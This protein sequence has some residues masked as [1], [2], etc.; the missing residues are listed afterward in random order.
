[1]LFRS[2]VRA[3]V[4]CCRRPASGDDVAMRVVVG[5]LELTLAEQ[6]DLIDQYPDPMVYARLVTGRALVDHD[7]TER[8]Q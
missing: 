3:V 7:R 5:V 8:I 2:L 4:R 6:L 1:M